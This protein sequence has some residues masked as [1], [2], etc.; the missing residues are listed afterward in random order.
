MKPVVEQAT[1]NDVEL[2]VTLGN[3]TF[4]DTFHQQ[5]TETDMQ[6][7]LSANFNKEIITEALLHP[8][9]TYWLLKE[10]DKVIGY[11]RLSKENHASFTNDI[12]STE[13]EQFYLDTAYKGKGYGSY[14]MQIILQKIK[15]SGCNAAWFGVWE[16]NTTA[17]QFYKKHGFI[18]FAEHD[19]VL[20]TDV[21]NDWLM[22]KQLY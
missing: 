7:F 17:I 11:C 13:I 14:F 6:M 18:K 10:D 16:H 21:Q 5:N 9:K 20:G 2:L 1:L 22:M 8:N 4:Y 3:K 12:H 19:F 15:E